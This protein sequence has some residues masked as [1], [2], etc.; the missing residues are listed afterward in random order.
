MNKKQY[1]SISKKLKLPSR[2]PLV[3]KCERW[4]WTVMFMGEFD[5]RSTSKNLIEILQERGIV[6][7]DFEKEMV[8]VFDELPEFH[9]S[10][11]Y[12][13]YHNMCPEIPLFNNE[14]RLWFMPE[15]ATTDGEWD[16]LKN[17]LKFTSNKFKH[18][19]ECLEFSRY[20]YLNIPKKTT[21]NSSSKKLSQRIPISTMLRFEIFQRDNF[22]C[23]YCGKTKNDG[24]KLVIDHKIPISKGGTDSIDNLV[25]A[26]NECNLG[27]SNKTV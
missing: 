4:A 19:S 11:V 27:K 3:G 2:C 26:C 23:Q 24:A 13:Y 22:T 6:N 16:D 21:T 12:I 14:L 25:T 17:E 20:H 5:K 9:R 15:L 1:S 7:G 8:E 18:Y 10:D